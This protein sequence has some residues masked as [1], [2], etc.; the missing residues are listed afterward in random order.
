[1]TESLPCSFLSFMD[2]PLD[3]LRQRQ[4]TYQVPALL[5]AGFSVSKPFIDSL[6]LLIWQH[7]SVAYMNQKGGTLQCRRRWH[8][9]CDRAVFPFQFEAVPG[10]VCYL[11][12]QLSM[13]LAFI[14]LS[15]ISE[16]LKN[17]FCRICVSRPLLILKMGNFPIFQIKV[18][19]A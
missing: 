2:S 10:L 13:Q 15:F 1:M 19:R 11:I 8:S 14:Q 17:Y 6:R 4:S 7:L 9:E 3:D 18:V 5:G 16:M 12:Q